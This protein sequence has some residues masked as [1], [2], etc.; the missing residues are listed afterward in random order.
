MTPEQIED[1]LIEWSIYSKTQQTEIIREYQMKFGNEQ[2]ESHWLNYLKD[3]LEI[4]DYWKKVGL[5]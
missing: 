5:K 3:V 1:L 4:E 2:G